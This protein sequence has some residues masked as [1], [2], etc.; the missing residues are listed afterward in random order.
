MI[1]F[2]CEKNGLLNIYEVDLVR[3]YSL[4]TIIGFLM[5]AL[6]LFYTK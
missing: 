5:L 3:Q 2:I 6:T 4:S 1:L